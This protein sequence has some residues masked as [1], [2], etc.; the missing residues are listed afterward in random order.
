MEQDCIDWVGYPVDRINKLT[1]AVV[2]ETHYMC[3]DHWKVKINFDRAR[4]EDHAGSAIESFR[5]VVEKGNNQARQIM[6]ESRDARALSDQT[7]G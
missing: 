6:L 3:L 2:T 4:F 5:N 7:S 1:G